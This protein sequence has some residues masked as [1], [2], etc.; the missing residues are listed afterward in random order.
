MTEWNMDISTAPKGRVVSSVIEIGK[1]KTRQI[2][3]FVPDI[4]IAVSRHHETIRSYWVPSKYTMDG[5]LLEGDRWAGFTRE[6]PP[7]AWMPW[8]TFTGCVE[9]AV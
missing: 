4:I 7:I 9:E 1:G 8:P 3:T 2:D 5:N 6:N